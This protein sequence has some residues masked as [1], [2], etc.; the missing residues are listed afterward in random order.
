MSIDTIIFDLG[1]VIINFDH[2]IA[3]KKIS[4]YSPKDINQ[5]YKLVFSSVLIEDF[6]KGLITP[7]DF[8][9]NL[10]RTLCLENLDYSEFVPIWNEI[11][12][13][14]KD[15]S[16]II[17][18]LKENNFKIILITNVN[19]LHLDYVKST[20]K[21][22]NKIDKIIASCEVGI[23]KPE[24][25]IYQLVQKIA[26]KKASDLIY[27]DDLVE[28]TEAAKGLGFSVINFDNAN[29]LKNELINYG[30]TCLR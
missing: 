11:F 24:P 9:S 13:E 8:F 19:K 23:R 18:I 25:Q 14:N 15:V 4:N 26:D 5:I 6:E 20:F 1:N 27:I 2:N 10:R 17:Q 28:L 30:I 7:Q 16:N 3:L 12:T 22:L 21:I 29:Q